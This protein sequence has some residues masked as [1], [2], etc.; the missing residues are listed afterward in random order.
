M[1]DRTFEAICG[2]FEALEK[3]V[4]IYKRFAMRALMSAAL[5]S[6]TTTVAQPTRVGAAS[7]EALGWVTGMEL[8][9]ELSRDSECRDVT[10]GY[11]VPAVVRQKIVPLMS[12]LGAIDKEFAPGAMKTAEKMLLEVGAVKQDGRRVIE[13]VYQ[14]SKAE[15]MRSS[16]GKPMCYAMYKQFVAMVMHR[17][18]NLHALVER[19]VR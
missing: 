18:Q 16:T 11:D 17:E 10:T 12:R 13:Q 9:N 6:S 1:Q 2:G 3:V 4:R 7:V 5:I 8:T 14:R 15:A 19:E